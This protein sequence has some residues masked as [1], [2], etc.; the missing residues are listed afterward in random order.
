ML[1]AWAQRAS[2]RAPASVNMWPASE[3][4]AKLPDQNPGADLGDQ[5]RAGEGQRDEETPPEEIAQVGQVGVAMVVIMAVVVTMAVLVIVTV[6][7]AVLG[8]HVRYYSPIGYLTGDS[9]R[10]P[11]SEPTVYRR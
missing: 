10:P 11:V 1:S 4:S 7:V 2:P 6:V 9:F 8:L 3:S 5:E